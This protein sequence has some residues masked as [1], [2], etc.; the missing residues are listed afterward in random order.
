MVYRPK[1]VLP[2]DKVRSSMH[3]FV[4]ALFCNSLDFIRCKVR[5]LL[6]QLVTQRR[7]V[8]TIGCL[9]QGNQA[10]G[11]KTFLADEVDVPF[12][13]ERPAVSWADLT[14]RDATLRICRLGGPRIGF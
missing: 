1:E 12:P 6:G 5:M 4:G 14:P 13:I 11:P 2:R 10:T 9:P 7:E 8:R 3:E